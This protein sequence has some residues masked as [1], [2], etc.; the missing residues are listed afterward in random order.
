MLYVISC[1]N[2]PDLNYTGGQDNIV[3]LEMS[4]DNVLNWADTNNKRCVFTT[5]NAAA[6]YCNDYDDFSALNLINWNA[7]NAD[8]WQHCREEKQAEFLIE[9]SIPW[10][11]IERIGVNSITVYKNVSAVLNQTKEHRPKIELMP[12]W[13]Y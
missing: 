4:L 12:Q 5:S 13:Y 10:S 2:N 7:V 3:H 8:N 1:R 9:N 11:L 6:Y